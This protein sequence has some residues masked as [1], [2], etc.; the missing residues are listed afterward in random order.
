VERKDVSARLGSRPS[1]VSLSWLTMEVALYILIGMMAAGLR[2]YALGA[3]PLQE[4]EATQA[5][6][7]PRFLGFG[8]WELG[9]DMYSPLLFLGN[10]FCFALLGASEAMARLVPA[11]SGTLLAI[12]PYFLRRR[13][14]RSGALAASVLLALSPSTLFF[15]RIW[16]DRLSSPPAFWPCWWASLAIWIASSRNMLI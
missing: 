14:G 8:N 11:L 10:L 4:N 7:G 16:G 12:L 13:L 6:A 1:T 15:S 2:F 9:I 3:Q 5:L